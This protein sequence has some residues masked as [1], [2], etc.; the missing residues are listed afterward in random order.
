MPDKS[1]KKPKQEKR[2]KGSKKIRGGV[3][4][5]ENMLTKF[6]NFITGAKKDINATAEKFSKVKTEIQQNISALN[7]SLNEVM[8]LLDECSS[9]L[10]AVEKKTDNAA[11][12]VFEQREQQVLNPEP[13]QPLQQ[14]Q[15]Q[16]ANPLPRIEPRMDQEESEYPRFGVGGGSQKKTRRKRQKKVKKTD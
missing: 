2:A 15:P 8:P 7:K 3:G 12:A 1:R 16:P 6:W 14:L 4:N 13:V 9:S 10:N 5:D 11:G